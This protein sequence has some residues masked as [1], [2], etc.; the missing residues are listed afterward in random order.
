M[1]GIV[2]GSNEGQL[3]RQEHGTGS[4]APLSYTLTQYLTNAEVA[5]QN[6]PDAVGASLNLTYSPAT[7]LRPV[8][9]TTLYQDGKAFQSEIAKSGSVYSLD[10]FARPQKQIKSSFTSLPPVA[11]SGT[12]TVSVPASST[13]GNYTVSWTTVAGATSYKLEQQI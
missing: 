6:F 12:S 2:Y 1:F 10:A 8:V 5:A 3:L 13:T 11:P 9:K 4:D 7:H